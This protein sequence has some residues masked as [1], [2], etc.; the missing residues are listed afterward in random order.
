MTTPNSF[1]PT[2]HFIPKDWQD[3]SAYIIAGGASLIGFDFGR[4]KGKNTV[5]VKAAGEYLPWASAYFSMDIVNWKMPDRLD[6]LRSAGFSGDIVMACNPVHEFQND[7]SDCKFVIRNVWPG[8]A[9]DFEY[10]MSV[11]NDRVFGHNSGYAALNYA[12]LRGAT[13]IYLLGFDFAKVGYWYDVD[14]RHWKNHQIVNNEII[15]RDR[16]ISEQQ[17][18][19]LNAS[20]F[21]KKH[22]IKVYIVGNESTLVGYDRIDY[23]KI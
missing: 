20:T 14:S 19:F 9:T 12:F 13:T 2:F 1:K 16:Y 8:Y 21:F 3:Q 18:K 10:P 6:K 11:W 7:V 5:A 17:N 4:L 22:G 15:T 23:G